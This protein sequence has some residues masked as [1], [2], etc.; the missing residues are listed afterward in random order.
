[1]CECRC[2]CGR[3]PKRQLWPHVVP[4]EELV[5]VCPGDDVVL[6]GER[7][8]VMLPFPPEDVVDHPMG[9]LDAKLQA[10]AI[11]ACRELWRLHVWADLL[12]VEF[13]L[14]SLLVEEDV[15]KMRFFGLPELTVEVQNGSAMAV[16]E[17]TLPSSR[18]LPMPTYARPFWAAFFSA[19]CGDHFESQ[20][21]CGLLREAVKMHH[22]QMGVDV[23]GFLKLDSLA[24]GLLCTG[25][26]NVLYC[27]REHVPPVLLIQRSGDCGQLSRLRHGRIVFSH[28]HLFG[29]LLLTREQLAEVETYR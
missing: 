2:S 15:I 14:T 26:F 9:H 21:L 11:E 6:I 10:I 19:C 18:R 1:M 8:Y 7:L 27:G 4:S 23:N 17:A 20:G 25:D 13:A 29:E 12:Q 3:S 16:I 5:C 22:L 28:S 24:E